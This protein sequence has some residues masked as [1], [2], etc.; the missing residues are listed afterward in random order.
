[1]ADP[2]DTTA[3]DI[4]RGSPTDPECMPDALAAGP[5]P[6]LPKTREKPFPAELIIPTDGKPYHKGGWRH[7]YHSEDVVSIP[8]SMGCDTCVLYA[9]RKKDPRHSLACPEGKKHA[10]CAILMRYQENWVASL[11]GEIRQATGRDPSAT[12]RARVEQI[13]RLRSRIFAIEVYIKAAGSIDLRTGELRNVMERLTGVENALTRAL[14][15]LRA[16]MAEGREA[17]KGPA[18]RLEE[19]LAAV[20]RKP[21]VA[22][23]V[24][25]RACKELL[26]VPQTSAEEVEGDG[27]ADE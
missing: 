2:E 5:P 13:V 23:E 22:V 7:G 27:S 24:E 18:P 26:P 25:E 15:E 21:P 17:R 3:R 20:V 10:A 19:Y 8:T 11:V 1:M 4:D 9:I 12:D 6:P 14:G 16:S